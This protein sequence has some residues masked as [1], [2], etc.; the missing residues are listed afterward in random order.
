MANKGVFHKGDPFLRYDEE[1]RGHETLCW[2]WQGGTTGAGYGTLAL[3]RRNHLAHRAYWEH[4]VGEIPEAMTIDHLCRVKNCVN[5]THMEPVSMT[6][7][8]RR[9]APYS[10]RRKLTDDQVLELRQEW[11]DALPPGASRRAIGFFDGMAEKYGICVAYAKEIC[12]QPHKR[13][14]P[15]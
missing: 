14:I 4:Y 6:E 12:Y 2:I 7:N 8:I 15:A 13:P 10:K 5:P 1:D 11:A 9:A 3:E